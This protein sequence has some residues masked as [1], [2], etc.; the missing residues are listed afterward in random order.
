M[1]LTTLVGK[2]LCPRPSEVENV[3]SIDEA[4]ASV[5]EIYGK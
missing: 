5:I 1:R 2:T 3:G 4:E